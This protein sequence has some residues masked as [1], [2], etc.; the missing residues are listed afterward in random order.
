MLDLTIVI[1]VR[2]SIK[3]IA[4]F[5]NEN[6]WLL[7]NSAVVVIDREGG[8]ILSYYADAYEIDRKS[9]FWE[10]RRK[11][12]KYVATKYI[13][14]L[15]AGAVVPI[16]YVKRAIKLMDEDDTIAVVSLD[17]EKLYGHLQFGVSIWRTNVLKELYDWDKTQGWCEC[18]YMWS[19]VHNIKM[20]IETLPYRA[21]RLRE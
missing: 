18:I 14:N 6:K 10:A 20:K 4:K 3:I 15:D 13:L 11:G 16:N 17:W 1:P 7:Q 12:Y 19:K 5:I 21:K 2:E 8:D 9:P